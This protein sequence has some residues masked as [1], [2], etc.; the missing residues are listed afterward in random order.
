[1][2]EN[3]GISGGH[4]LGD[5]PFATTSTGKH[6]KLHHRGLGP[7]PK[8]NLVHF[9]HKIWHPGWPLVWKTWK[10]QG[11]WQLSGKCQDFTKSQGI[12]REKNLVMEN[13]LK[14]FI[15]SCIF[16]SIQVF[17]RSL[18]CVNG[19]GSCTI[20]FLPLP[21]IVTLVHDMSNN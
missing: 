4:I 13:C 7:Q 12:V 14:L 21:L 16:A 11:I 18:F 6:C 10:C 1:M 19:L 17:N 2:C 15:V 3:S 5:C 8:S 20:A 9:G